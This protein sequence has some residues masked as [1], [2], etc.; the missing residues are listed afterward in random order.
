[1]KKWYRT[2]AGTR[3]FY[4][5]DKSQPNLRPVINRLGHVRN[6]GRKLWHAEL[7]RTGEAVELES[8]AGAKAWVEMSDRLA[9]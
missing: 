3:I 8:L 4:N 1:M 6:K 5:E 9:G 2:V 7:Y